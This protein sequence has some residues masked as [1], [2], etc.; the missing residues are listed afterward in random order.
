MKVILKTD[1]KGQGKKGQMVEVSDG[2]AR[3]FLLPR[4][5]ASEATKSAVNDF[6]GKESSAQFHKEQEIK[7][8][9]E[10]AAKIE[11]KKVVI[12]AK[13][14]ANG[15]LFGA[16]TSQIVAEALKM[17]LHVVVDKKKLVMNDI[18]T[19]GETKVDVKIYPEISAGIT[20]SVEEE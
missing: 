2:Y 9:K 18:K 12:K 7:E 14:G 6:K 5:L 10:I 17:Q 11:G 8:A 13:A 20:V 4:G 19:V 15:K 16:I 1:V 3:N